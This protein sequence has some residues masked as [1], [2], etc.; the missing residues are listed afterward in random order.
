MRL[1]NPKIILDFRHIFALVN[2]NATS[3]RT[4]IVPLSDQVIPI[5]IPIS[6][7]LYILFIDLFPYHPNMNRGDRGA[8]SRSLGPYVI[9]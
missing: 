9:I 6:D 4:P 5:P 1:F 2:G 8:A 7:L 3:T